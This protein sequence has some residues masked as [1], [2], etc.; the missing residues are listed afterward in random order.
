MVSVGGKPANF[1]FIVDGAEKA[2]D[3]SRPEI[4]SSFLWQGYNS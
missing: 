3:E 4:A 1:K 2:L